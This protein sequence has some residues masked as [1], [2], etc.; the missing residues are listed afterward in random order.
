MSSDELKS[1]WEE[2]KGNWEQLKG[3]WEQFKGKLREKWP[4]FTDNDWQQIKGDKEKMVE[5]IQEKCG[6]TK[7]QAEKELCDFLNKNKDHH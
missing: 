1:K 7:E 5:K 3:N 2:L 6:I 4:S